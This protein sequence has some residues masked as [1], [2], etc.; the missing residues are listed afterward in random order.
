VTS[1]FVPCFIIGVF[2][3]LEYFDTYQKWIT[4]ADGDISRMKIVV[5]RV[6]GTIVL[7]SFTL[8]SDSIENITTFSGN[9][10]GPLCSFIIPI[11]LLNSKAW[12][13]EGKLRSWGNLVHDGLLLTFSVVMTVYGTY[14]SVTSWF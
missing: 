5:I 7:M 13:L 1:L 11:V 8:I 9:L 3:P 6:I 10:F 12:V 2:E 14:N 4:G